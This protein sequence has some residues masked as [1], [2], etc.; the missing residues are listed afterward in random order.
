MNEGSGDPL[1]IVHLALAAG[2]VLFAAVLFGFVG[3]LETVE[4]G[5]LRWV[6]LGLAVV[7]V[8]AAGIVRGRLEAPGVEA[9]QR[10][11]G[12]IVIWALA[13]GQA[14]VG[15]VFYMLTGDVVPAVVGVL[16]FFFLWWRYRP[17]ALP[18]AS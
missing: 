18:G 9:A 15:L 6:W 14:L 4:D 13:E 11:A 7:A 16:L 1:P 10:R 8:V 5:V 3:P 2:V 17:T 12:A